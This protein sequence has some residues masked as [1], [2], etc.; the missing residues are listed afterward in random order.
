MTFKYRPGS[1]EFLNNPHEA[2]DYM[3]EN[4]PVYFSSKGF[5]VITRYDDVA[6]T[7]RNST[8][9]VQYTDYAEGSGAEYLKRVKE[10]QQRNPV[11]GSWKTM[12]RAD[13]PD[14]DRLKKFAMPHFS[15]ASVSKM[16][17]TIKDIVDNR[18][19]RAATISLMGSTGYVDLVH[20]VTV[21]IA[22]DTICTMIDIPDGDRDR[23]CEWSNALS[24]ALE[25]L[26][27]NTTGVDNVEEFLPQVIEYLVRQLGDRVSNPRPGDLISSFI[28]DEIDGEKLT[29]P[30]V[31]SMT[32]MMFLAGIETA[33]Y[34]MANAVYTLLANEDVREQWIDILNS[35]DDTNYENPLI[36]NAVE[37]LLR[38]NG[39][40]WQTMRVNKE[41]TV[42]V[43]DGVETVVP[44]GTIINL[45]I[46]AANRDPRIFKNPHVIDLRRDNAKRNIGF[47]AGPHYC[48]GANI[49]KVQTV[50]LLKSIFTNF[51]KAKLV[52]EPV[53]RNRMTFRGVEKL[54]VSL[55]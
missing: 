41:D 28:H 1:P 11:I 45:S 42:Y 20:E 7:L 6:T 27:A 3:R 51:P 48:L 35:S 44:R 30:E 36:N 32:G 4:H 17:N 52:D 18:V 54:N 55:L 5:V 43:H 2:Y 40:V 23:L 19:R 49:A 9:S 50:E 31:I 46:A 33:T 22:Q 25:P 14:H 37:E 34:F 21:Q 47:S 39:S 24:M 8:M 15:S 12:L 10:S 53:W 16:A 26:Q 38:Y 13:N 29:F